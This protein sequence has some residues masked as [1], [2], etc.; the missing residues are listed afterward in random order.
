MTTTRDLTFRL[1]DMRTTTPGVLSVV[2]ATTDGICQH[3][4]GI[5]RDEAD[6]QAA[7]AA[8]LRAS[9]MRVPVE[10]VPELAEHSSGLKFLSYETDAGLSPATR[11]MLSQPAS[12]AV[13][14]AV[15][16]DRCSATAL[17][18]ALKRLGDQVAEWW[19][20]APRTSASP[21]AG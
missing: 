10:T 16:D 11:T 21:L 13:L 18:T 7:L 8:S 9:A 6:R 12:G 17:A 1:T 19:E 4:S 20:T 2:H 3:H 15:A 5:D 14:V